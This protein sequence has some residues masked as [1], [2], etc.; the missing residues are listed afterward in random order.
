MTMVETLGS[1]HIY[2]CEKGTGGESFLFLCFIGNCVAIPYKA[3]ALRVDAHSRERKLLL[4]Q[5][6]SARGFLKRNPFLFGCDNFYLKTF[7]QSVKI[8]ETAYAA[9]YQKAGMQNV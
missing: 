7:F 4:S 9:I 1:N 3:K 5:P 8:S 2:N 6:R